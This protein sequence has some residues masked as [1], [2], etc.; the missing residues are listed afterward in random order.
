VSASLLPDPL[1]NR[2]THTYSE[3]Y[4]SKEALLRAVNLL[5]LQELFAQLDRAI[6][7]VS[8]DGIARLLAITQT[9]RRFA[10]AQPNLYILAMTAEVGVTRPDENL[11]VQMI[12]PIQAIVAEISGEARSLTAL[13]GFFALIHGFVMLELHG[14]FQRGGSL[15]SAFSDSVVAYLSGWSNN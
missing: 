8:G 5:T 6:H 1:P 14:Q 15:D 9:Y 2:P 13:R 4:F 7:S 10:H 11:Q 3:G 12:L